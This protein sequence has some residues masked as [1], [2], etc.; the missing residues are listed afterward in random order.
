MPHRPPLC[1]GPARRL[2]QRAQMQ[3]QAARD[4]NAAGIQSTVEKL[5]EQEH[6]LGSSPYKAFTTLIYQGTG[7]L[8]Q[9][10]ESG[11]KPNE[12]QEG[13]GRGPLTVVQPARQSSWPR[14]W[15]PYRPT[16]VLLSKAGQGVAASCTQ[17]VCKYLL[18]ERK[19]SNGK[20]TPGSLK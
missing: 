2:Q 7:G 4:S 15:P 1:P 12:P 13:G 14:S 10:Q 8:L 5:V 9:N 3:P 17:W 18:N 20:R 6:V 11:L 19:Y 16:D